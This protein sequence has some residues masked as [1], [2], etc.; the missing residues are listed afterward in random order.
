MLAAGMQDG[1]DHQI[2][3]REKPFF[4][5]GAGGF[6]GACQSAKVFVFRKAVQM[7][8]ADPGQRGDFILGENFL[9]LSDRDHF[10]RSPSLML[11]P[12]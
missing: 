8:Q 9:A 11:A 5:F 3:V 2:R 10:L 1:E 6:R 7:F 4:G 12:D